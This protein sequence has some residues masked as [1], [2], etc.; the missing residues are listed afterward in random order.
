MLDADQKGGSLC[1]R[2]RTLLVAKISTGRKRERSGSPAV[3]S[4]AAVLPAYAPLRGGS[5]LRV[6]RLRRAGRRSAFACI[7]ERR[8]VSLNF[9]SWNQLDGWLRQVEGLKRVA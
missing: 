3:A 4:F 9:T 8:L 1:T 2:P 7:H 6:A 5:R